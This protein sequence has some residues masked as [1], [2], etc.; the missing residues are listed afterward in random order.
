MLAQRPPAL[1]TASMASVESP[2]PPPPVE[3]QICH[4]TSPGPAPS[5]DALLASEPHAED[6]QRADRLAARITAFLALESRS[7]TPTSSAHPSSPDL[8]APMPASPEAIDRATAQLDADKPQPVVSPPPDANGTGRAKDMAAW[9]AQVAANAT[10]PK[11]TAMASAVRAKR[12]EPVMHGSSEIVHAAS[13]HPSLLA[14]DEDGSPRWTDE[15]ASTTSGETV[16]GERPTITI[17]SSTSRPLPKR[18]NTGAESLRA[19][20]DYHDYLPPRE[21]STPGGTPS[22][23]FM[24]S[25][26]SSTSSSNLKALRKGSG[27]LAMTHNNDSGSIRSASSAKPEAHG[28]MSDLKRFVHN[29]MPHSRKSTMEQPPSPGASE[30]SSSVASDRTAGT[31]ASRQTSRHSQ[32]SQQHEKGGIHFGRKHS[33]PP[34]GEDHAHMQ[35]KYG[36]WGKVLGS[37]AGGTVRLVRRPKDHTIFAVKEF[38]PK[39]ANESERDYVKKVT[40]EFCIGSTLHHPNIIETVDIISDNGHYYE[41]MQYAEYDLFSIVMS[42]RMSR[43]E[44]YCVWKQIIDG[45]DYLHSMG[46]AHRDLKLDSALPAMFPHADSARL[47]RHARLDDQAHRLWHRDRVP[48]S[49]S[50]RPRP[51]QGYRRLGSLPC[52][53]GPRPAGRV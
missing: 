38:R 9:R 14:P 48:I 17:P 53:R 41:V 49:E 2:S 32:S 25:P 4:S 40:A 10:T 24:F 30:R 33:P 29:H 15:P 36:K 43:P 50:A 35:K 52:A 22:A 44:V 21:P 31:A 3:G 5:L 37:G 1:R 27:V 23:Q 13:H 26:R 46:L 12:P 6:D 39:R 19:G 16:R 45:V 47:R 20:E 34:L 42:G 18:S 28:V 11:A 51:R 7:G 8:L